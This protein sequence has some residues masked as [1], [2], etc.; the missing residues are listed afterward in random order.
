MAQ[1]QCVVVTWFTA[2]F[3]IHAEQAGSWLTAT[4]LTLPVAYTRE[5]DLVGRRAPRLRSRQPVSRI[6][7]P[8][9]HRPGIPV[10][11][12]VKVRAQARAIQCVEVAR[13]EVAFPASLLV[14]HMCP[15]AV[16]A[17]VAN[18]I[19]QRDRADFVADRRADLAA[20][21]HIA[22]VGRTDLAAVVE[23]LTATAGHTADCRRDATERRA[24][25]CA[26]RDVRPRDVMS[27]Y[28]SCG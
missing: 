8:I 23:V 25:F 13:V 12:R 26:G 14:A 22:S 10:T 24:A 6:A 20:V 9:G 27:A 7:L 2:I 3:N 19:V 16:D 5:G 4:L 11:I 18:D 15:A 1:I 28:L 17:W 21:R